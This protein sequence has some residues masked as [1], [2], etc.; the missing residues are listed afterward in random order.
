MELVDR[1][2]I[3]R[4][5]DHIWGVKMLTG[6]SEYLAFATV[7]AG[8]FG[9]ADEK[10]L[11]RYNPIRRTISR[12]FLYD[13]LS[14]ARSAGLFPAPTLESSKKKRLRTTPRTLDENRAGHGHLCQ[15]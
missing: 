8:K 12:L 10:Y 11:P 9:C 6:P 15:K 13:H 4:R 14:T 1:L 3:F 2:V 7:P 5:I